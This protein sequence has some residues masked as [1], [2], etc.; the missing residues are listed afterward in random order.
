MF[1]LLSHPGHADDVAHTLA[2]LGARAH[3]AT[4]W[5]VRIEPIGGTAD[6]ADIERELDN[7]NSRRSGVEAELIG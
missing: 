5:V 4:D 1:V 2:A 6:R 3:K 7:W